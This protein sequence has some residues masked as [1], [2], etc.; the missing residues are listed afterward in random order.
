MSVVVVRGIASG[1]W[2]DSLPQLASVLGSGE[3][4]GPDEARVLCEVMAEVAEE[5]WEQ[6]LRLTDDERERV[7][8][9]LASRLPLV[10]D[11]MQG[12]LTAAASERAVAR[13]A[14]LCLSSWWRNVAGRPPSSIVSV[15]AHPVVDAAFSALQLPEL[16]A[17]AAQCAHELLR[18]V[19]LFCRQQSQPVSTSS[20]TPSPWQPA[21]QRD[22]DGEDGEQQM[23][24]VSFLRPLSEQQSGLQLSFTARVLALLPAYSQLSSAAA[25]SIGPHSTS[26]RA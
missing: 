10:L 23:Q 7:A 13:A 1:E 2:S 18:L 3:T 20:S 25:A 5:L 16:D 8:A 12:M 6:Q 14:L 11:M 26:A 17:A 19:E 9:Y 4:A 15:C 21:L 24:L 22:D